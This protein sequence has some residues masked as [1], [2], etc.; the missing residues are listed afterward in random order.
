MM[1]AQVAISRYVDPEDSDST[2][3][4]LIRIARPCQAFSGQSPEVGRPDRLKKLYLRRLLSCGEVVWVQFP[5][6]ID[7]KQSEFDHLHRVT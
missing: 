2:Q 5:V 4:L 6:C 7:E 3:I 1:P